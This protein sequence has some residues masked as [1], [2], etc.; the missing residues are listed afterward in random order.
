MYSSLKRAFSQHY[1]VMHSNILDILSKSLPAKPHY[2]FGDA[3]VGAAGHTLTLLEAFPN[4]YVIGTDLDAD[5][6]KI[7][8]QNTEKYQDRV[9][10]HHS[11]YTQLHTFP[12]FPDILP[13]NQKFDAVLIDLGMSSIQLDTAERG[14]S[15]SKEGPL[16]MRFNR[17]ADLIPTAAKIINYASELELNEIFRKYGEEK[18]S[19]AAADVICRLRREIK[20]ETT[21][22]LSKILSYAFYI[23]RSSNKYESITKCFQAL[24]IKVNDELTHVHK[25][26]NSIFDSIENDG[27]LIAISF[28]SLEEKIV[29]EFMNQWVITI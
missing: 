18:N 7:A 19:K 4:S 3:T 21:T 17:D 16:D 28:H 13:P 29:K 27:V 2:L 1:P 6:L 26:F 20:I 24:R 12:R 11:N 25:F 10:L 14:F 22:Q 8:T 5:A 15:F 23:S 9:A